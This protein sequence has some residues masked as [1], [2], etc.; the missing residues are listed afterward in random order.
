M[1]L[2]RT[3]TAK[4]EIRDQVL[5]VI[6]SVVFNEDEHC[7]IDPTTEQQNTLNSLVE[8]GYLHLTELDDDA[9]DY[10]EEGVITFKITLKLMAI[11]P[12]ERE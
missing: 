2:T 8:K 7:I 4:K 9:D 6:E 11:L 1:P 12:R 5:K 10:E 3:Q